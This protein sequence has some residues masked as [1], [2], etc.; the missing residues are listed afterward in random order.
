[1]TVAVSKAVEEGAEA[2]I[3]ASTGN[4]AASCAAY[5]ARAGIPAV[6]LTPAGRR[7]RAEGGADADARREGTRGARRLRP[8][9]RGRAGARR[10]RHARARQLGQPEPPCGPEDGGLRDRGGARQPHRRGSCIPYGGGGNTSAYA[11]G[12]R[13][14]RARDRDLLR[15]GGAPADDDGLGDPDRSSRAMPTSVRASG[16]TVITVSDDEI[17][18]AWLE[19]AA[20][21]GIFC[22]PSSAAGL[23]AIRR[24][25]VPG[26]TARRHDHRPRPQGHRQ[27]RPLRAGAPAG[28]R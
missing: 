8:R 15:R 19:L 23:A 12:D 28:G 6:V 9:A 21:E 1:M 7:R 4:T 10:P 5:A 20:T 25:D 17:V 16:A 27:R 13:R 18:A 24:G 11:H 22:E 26:E 2:V 14:A 3:C